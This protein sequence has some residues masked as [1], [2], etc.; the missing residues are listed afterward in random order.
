MSFFEPQFLAKNKERRDGQVVAISKSGT[1]VQVNADQHTLILDVDV[2]EGELFERHG[3]V[4]V[5]CA[6]A[7]GYESA[8]DAWKRRS[9]KGI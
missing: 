6:L 4:R 2:L 7:T 5:S 9:Q 8:E 1:R 3:A